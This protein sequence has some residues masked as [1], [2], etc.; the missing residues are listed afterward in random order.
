MKKAILIFAVMFLT[1]CASKENKVE[2]STVSENVQEIAH[3]EFSNPTFMNGSSFGKF[4]ISMLRTQNYEMALAFTS[5]GS[6]EK[7]GSKAI[8][9]A[10]KLFD[11]NYELTQKSMVKSNDTITI[12]YTTNEMA[13]GKLKK[14]TLVLENDTCKLVLPDNLQNLLR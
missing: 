1:S 14:M 10:Y 2:V 9:N 13:T 12:V 7:F 8:L 4:F 5:K 6:K 3:S 11:R